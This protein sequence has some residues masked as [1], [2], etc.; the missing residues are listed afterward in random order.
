MNYNLF[1]KCASYLTQLKTKRGHKSSGYWKRLLEVDTIKLFFKPVLFF[2]RRKTLVLTYS[3]FKRHKK[4]EQYLDPLVEYVIDN[5]DDDPLVLEKNQRFLRFIPSYY[6]SSELNVLVL[7]LC[8]SIAFL[9]AKPIEFLIKILNKLNI[10][11]NKLPYIRIYIETHVTACYFML[12]ILILRP[13]NVY[14]AS[15]FSIESM[16]LCVSCNL[17]KIKCSE[18]QHGNIIKS[19]PIYNF[20]WLQFQPKFFANSFVVKNDVVKSVLLSS[21]RILDKKNITIMNSEVLV[22]KASNCLLVCLGITDLPESVENFINTSDYDSIILRPHP[23]FKDLDLSQ[24]KNVTRL[25]TMDNT[26]LS[27]DKSIG[28][29][30]VKSS[31]ILCGASTVIIDAYSSGHNI[32]TWDSGSFEQYDEYRKLIKLI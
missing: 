8:K 26:Q 29:D 27:Q 24:F 25:L 2:K 9:I 10:I 22:N 15:Q 28:S 7:L 13:K 12:I 23:G 1:V 19:S 18:I 17:L 6:K 16:A 11:D 31:C 4:D 30:L 21:S 32:Y 20:S 14:F 5:I 3:T